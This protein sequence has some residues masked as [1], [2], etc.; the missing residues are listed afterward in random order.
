MKKLTAFLMILC[1]LFCI[2]GCKEEDTNEV[3]E[4]EFRIVVLNNTN[5]DIKGV[6]LYYSVFGKNA[7]SIFLKG[8]RETVKDGETL[9]K[10][11]TQSEFEK[12]SSLAEF[13]IEALVLA[14]DSSAKKTVN[15]VKF[16]VTYGET[17]YI[18]L[19][20]NLDTNFHL[21]KLSTPIKY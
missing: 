14:K 17:Y 4:Q 7:G 3:T 1:L 19:D 16:S 21:S 12:F 11:F 8:E 9:V 10:T 2:C 6:T 13:E 18:M 5:D 20:G 15:A